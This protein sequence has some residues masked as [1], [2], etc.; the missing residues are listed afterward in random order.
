MLIGPSETPMRLSRFTFLTDDE[1]QPSDQS[2]LRGAS[3]DS[4][5]Q[6]PRRERQRIGSLHAINLDGNETAE[7]E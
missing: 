1:A 4:K 2:S 6:R 7:C 3:A 5:P